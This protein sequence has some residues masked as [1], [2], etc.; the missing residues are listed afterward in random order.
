MSG[1]E[2]E[3]GWQPDWPEILINGRFLGQPV[4][5]VQRYAR[6]TLAALD[7]V[8]DAHDGA[9]ARW[10]VL[11]PRGTH[12][13]PFRHLAVETVGRVQGH[14]WEQTALA[15]R[16]RGRLLFSFGSTGPALKRRQIITVHDA[17]VVRM[18]QAFRRDFVHWYRWLI[19]TIGARAP[20]TM[21]VSEFSASEAASCFGVPTERLR[22]TTEGWQHLDALAADHG[23]LDRHALRGRPFVLAV[24]SP[25]PNKNFVAIAQALALLGTD[26]PRCVVVGASDLAVFRGAAVDSDNLLHVGR[27]SDAELKSL[28]LHASCFVFPSFYE[29]F[30]IPPLEAMAC[31]CPVLASTAPAVR[32]V[33]GAAALYFDP[34]HPEELAEGLR[35]LASDAALRATMRIDGLARARHFSWHESA[36]LNLAAIREVMAT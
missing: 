21:A 15:W 10:T 30:G 3:P 32:E 19:R 20:R 35:R 24:S 18:P 28:Y 34:A 13:P 31:G 17:A 12:A 6:E 11:V 8:L 4:T 25:T 9:G 16:A 26:A 5:G 7:A 14:L 33:C 1:P 36:L 27:V 29:G 23:I 22:V 2:T